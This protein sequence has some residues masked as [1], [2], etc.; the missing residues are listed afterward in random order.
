M[1]GRMCHIVDLGPTTAYEEPGL[2]KER[3]SCGP[4]ER[5]MPEEAKD[6][7]TVSDACAHCSLEDGYEELKKH[8]HSYHHG[9]CSLSHDYTIPSPFIDGP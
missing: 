9:G 7:L 5:Y 3:M 6:L 4:G 1:T 8:H 2:P